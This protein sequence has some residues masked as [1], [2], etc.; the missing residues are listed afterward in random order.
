MNSC[1]AP[2]WAQAIEMK[3][4]AARLDT[5]PIIAGKRR[6]PLSR[7]AQGSTRCLGCGNPYSAVGANREGT[8]DPLALGAGA[9]D[10][11]P[12]ASVLKVAGLSEYS[13]QPPALDQ[14]FTFARAHRRRCFKKSTNGHRY[15]QL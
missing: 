7:A 1:A 10:V 3:V 13:F 15:R 9:C 11:C 4:M 8:Q 14:G 12:G 5:T 6:Q 2:A